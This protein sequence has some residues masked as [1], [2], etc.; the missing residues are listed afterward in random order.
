MQCIL[1]SLRNE[2]L[3]IHEYAH[4]HIPIYI[5]KHINSYI[6]KHTYMPHIQALGG[7]KSNIY[8]KELP[9]YIST[10]QIKNVLP[11]SFNFTTKKYICKCR[12]RLNILQD[13]Q[14]GTVIYFRIYSIFESYRSPDMSLWCIIYNNRRS[15]WDLMTGVV[16]VFPSIM[17]ERG[18]V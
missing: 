11:D 9:L 14:C 1:E 10:Q 8:F 15:V 6:D 2:Y 12:Q 5:S 16:H 7:M 4:K 17:N 18:S 13:N 3:R